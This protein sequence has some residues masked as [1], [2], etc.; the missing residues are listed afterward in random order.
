MRL[1]ILSDLHLEFGG[2]TPI[3]ETDADVV[4][5]AG[6]I[7]LGSEGCRWA[8]KHF[9]KQPVIYVLGNHEFYR[10][11]LP[12]LTDT[13]KAEMEGSQICVLEN[14]SV[15]I[16]G[17]TFLGCTLWTDFELTGDPAMAMQIAGDGM[18]DYHIIRYNPEHR[19]LDPRDTV[20]AHRESVAWLRSALAQVNPAQTV[21]VTHHSPSPRAEAPYH[22]GSPLR[23]AFGSHLDAL[24]ESSGVPLWI[25]GHTHHNADFKIG[26]TRVL[27]N[28]CGYPDRPCAGF[29][30]GLVVEI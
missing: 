19:M 3:P 8:R 13:L 17:Y 10:H 20:R 27:S 29:N 24:V 26:A 2:G 11:S 6:D 16:G 9:P 4:I 25:Y 12:S 23:A 22:A 5:L 18:S 7:H 21:V 14:N 28:Q 30:P 1:H 15:E